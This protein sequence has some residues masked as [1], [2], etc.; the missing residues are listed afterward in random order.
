VGRSTQEGHLT[1]WVDPG[2]VFEPGTASRAGVDLARLLWLRGLR[3][4]RIPAGALRSR[5]LSALGVLLGSGLFEVVVLDVVGSPAC[6]ARLPYAVWLRLGRL[7]ESTSSS[8]VVLAR[9]P[10]ARSPRGIS[11]SLRPVR[12]QWSGKAGPGRLLQALETRV[13]LD[14]YGTRDASLT[15]QAVH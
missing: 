15:L 4:S 13:V 8:L 1:A 7:I 14:H 12:P 2:D 5:V 6:L 11:L 10:T 9:E 3:E